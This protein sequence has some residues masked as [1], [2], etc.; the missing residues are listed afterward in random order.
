M[1]KNLLSLIVLLSIF[2]LASCSSTNKIETSVYVKVK[3]ENQ[4]DDPALKKYDTF[5]E[6]SNSITEELSSI[7]N[8]LDNLPKIITELIEEVKSIEVFATN[9][10]NRINNIDKVIDQDATALA[11]EMDKIGKQLELLKND[12]DKIFELLLSKIKTAKLT[13]KL[14]VK[15]N[16]VKVILIPQIFADFES[17]KPSLKSSTITEVEDIKKTL[18]DKIESFNSKFEEI[19]TSIVAIKDSSIMI[20]SDAKSLAGK[21]K[22]LPGSLKADFTGMNAMKI[23][24]VTKDLASAGAEL[25]KV[26]AQI[27]K[28][29]EQT[30]KIITALGT[31]F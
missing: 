3:Y 30:P 14:T 11:A 24:S 13:I 4:F 28:I 2:L 17:M 12:P 25:A 31:V 7:E 23:P 9:M 26:P 16:G 29:L 27:A 8:N 15:E 21:A 18:N 1:K 5:F 10:H 6:K 22:D 19:F 20:I